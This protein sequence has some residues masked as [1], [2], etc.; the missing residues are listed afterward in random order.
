MINKLLFFDIDGT[1]LDI[2]TH[3]IP[4]DAIQAIK[5]AQQNNCKVF[6]NTGRPRSFISKEILDLNPDGLICGCGTYIEVDGEV[7][8]HQSLKNEELA[9]ILKYSED[10]TCDLILESREKIYFSDDLNNKDTIEIQ[11]HYNNANFPLGDI[12]SKDITIDKYCV[13]FEDYDHLQAYSDLVPNLNVIDRGNN[14]IE[15]IPRSLNKGTGIEYVA[16]H[17]HKT[18]DDCIGFG[19]S[20]N[21]I[22]MLKVVGTAVAMQDSDQQT[23]DIASYVT[24]SVNNSGIKKALEYLELI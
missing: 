10:K 15:V 20:T 8:F 9:T 18:L 17:Y 1:L 7:L 14:F 22:D 6:I 19:D 23:L 21:D 5:Q 24:S 13:W 2:A 11:K 12:N 4:D 16:N 3:T